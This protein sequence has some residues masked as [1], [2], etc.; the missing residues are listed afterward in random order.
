M[1]FTISCCCGPGSVSSGACAGSCEVWRRLT[2]LELEEVK[3]FQGL[4]FLAA[5]DLS[6][7]RA[8]LALGG[9]TR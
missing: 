3:V 6:A 1:R 7:P 5:V 8:P 2:T 4:I 9:D